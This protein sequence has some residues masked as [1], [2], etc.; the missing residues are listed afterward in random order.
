MVKKSRSTGFG[1]DYRLPESAQGLLAV[2]I[3]VDRKAG[4]QLATVVLQLRLKLG[5]RAETA[6]A[7]GVKRAARRRIQRARQLAGQL[8]AL[9]A[10]VRVQTRRCRQ[11]RLRVRMRGLL[12]I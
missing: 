9:A 5:A 4:Y 1:F 12:K 2:L 6:T 7:A 10:V 8:D 3:L 11:Q